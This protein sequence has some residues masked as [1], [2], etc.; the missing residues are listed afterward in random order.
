MNRHIELKVIKST[1][2]Y[3]ENALNEIKLLQCLVTSSTPP[4]PST[5]TQLNPMGPHPLTLTLVDHTSSPF[6]ITSDKKLIILHLNHLDF[7]PGN[8]II[9]VDDVKSIIQSELAKSASNSASPPTKL[10]GVPP[11]K[12]RE[13]NQTSR[14]ES[15]LIHSL[16]L[17][18]SS[19][20]G[21]S[22][23]LNKLAFGMSR[24]DGE[25]SKPSSVG[26]TG[27]IVPREMRNEMK[28]LTRDV[29]SG[30]EMNE[31][32]D[33]LLNISIDSNEFNKAK[34]HPSNPSGMSL[35]TQMM[36]SH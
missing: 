2:R 6:S 19:S 9:C 5:L 32:T 11:S 18:P 26:S 21:S 8:V 36:P 3:T 33:S 10:V 15:I 14:L 16:Q 25:G 12:D 4:F 20:F 34:L 30:S 29:S 23:M 31:A 13:G 1:P 28:E 7:K 22:P 27:T 35:L 24:I 17:L